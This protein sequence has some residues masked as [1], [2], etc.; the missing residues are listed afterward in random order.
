MSKHSGSGP[1]WAR[2]R[3]KILDRDNWRCQTC[4]RWGNECDHIKPLQWGGEMYSESN[5][6]ILCRGC[7]ITKTRIENTRPNPEKEA[8]QS[9]MRDAQN[10]QL[11]QRC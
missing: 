8:W 10:E 1:V 4:G 3:L 11:A 9:F 6:Q 7:H 5:C 2:F